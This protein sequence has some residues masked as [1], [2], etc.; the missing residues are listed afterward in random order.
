MAAARG[1]SEWASARSDPST[2][3][4]GSGPGGAADLAATWGA[5]GDDANG[6]TG[7]SSGGRSFRLP[8]ASLTTASALSTRAPLAEGMVA[9]SMDLRELISLKEREL[10]DMNEFRIQN[11]ERLVHEK[12]RAERAP[13][14]RWT[15]RTT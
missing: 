11:L 6:A 10:H 14:V 5:A 7:R 4:F 9:P 12:V 8:E 13:G 1:R 15:S 3:S 2:H